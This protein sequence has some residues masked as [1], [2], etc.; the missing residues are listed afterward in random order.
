MSKKPRVGLYLSPEIIVNNPGYLEALV[1]KIGLNW[2]IIWFN[3]QL[4]P[5]VLAA[6]PFDGAPP[7]PE[8]VRN[9]LAQHLDGQPSTNKLDAALKAIGPH[10]GPSDAE[11]DA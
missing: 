7:S 10:V 3:G 1:E 11:Q 6:S 5:E 4:P 9:L 8:R 2:V